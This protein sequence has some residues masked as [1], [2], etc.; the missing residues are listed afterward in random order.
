MVRWRKRARQTGVVLGVSAALAGG[1][2]QAARRRPGPS[3][4]APRWCRT[5][6]PAGASSCSATR[7][8][9]IPS[10]TSRPG[11]RPPAGGNLFSLQ[12]GDDELLTQPPSAGRA[13]RAARG[14][15][16]PVPHAQP[17]ARRQDGLRGAQLHAFPPTTRTTSST[18]SPASAPGRPGRCR[19][20]RS[21][22]RAELFLV[23]DDRQ[24]D[25]AL[26]PIKHR[27]TVTYTLRRTGIRFAYR[28]DN[29][30]T[31]PPP[32]RLRAAPLL[33][34]PGR[35]E[36]GADARSRSTSGWRRRRCCPPAS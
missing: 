10:G 18:A 16:H 30:D 5:R 32:L 8:R 31:Q 23:W 29:L 25:F 20:T 27:L 15:A 19:P 1:D 9:A 13:D 35:P 6:A 26:F 4:S 11:S 33:S 28:V 17:G 36:R 24:P 2:G 3:P 34:H 22:A 14:N 21:S 12:V 7:T